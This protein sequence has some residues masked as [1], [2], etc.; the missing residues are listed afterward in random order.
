MRPPDLPAVFTRTDALK[1]GLSDYRLRGL[2]RSGV[3]VRIR[4]GLYEMAAPVAPPQR[5]ARAVLLARAALSMRGPGFVA[6][7]VT[8]A[9]ALGLPLPLGPLDTVHL[10]DLDRRVARTRRCAGLWIHDADSYDTD[11]EIVDDLLV[12]SVARTVAD[13][14][15]VFRAETSVPIADAA[16]HL[17]LVTAEEVTAELAMQCHWNGRALRADVAAPLVDGRRESWLESFAAVKF[18]QWEIEPPTPQLIILDAD[19]TFVARAD[20]G[21]EGDAVVIEIDGKAKYA[22]PNK[23]VVDPVGAWEEEKDRFDRVGD[24]GLERVRFGL[25]HLLHESE[26]VRR[27]VRERRHVGSASRFTGSFR[28]LPDEGLRLI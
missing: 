25:H 9:A 14:L 24:L 23:G 15:R 12:T 17:R 2:V 8:A 18:D 26:L 13:C 1:L 16:L 28:L 5:A 3:V 27:R 7:H 20:A 10:T 22:L 19:Q 11:V 6:S 21:W 4:N